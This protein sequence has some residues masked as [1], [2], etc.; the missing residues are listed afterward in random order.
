[1]R[2]ID[3]ATIDAVL[4]F[5]VLVDALHAAH[6]RPRMEVQDTLLGHEA[7][8]YFVRS[9]ND[10]GRFMASKLVT[11][12]PG[13]P[14]RSTLPSV[15]GVVVLFDGTDGRPLVA[16]DGTALTAWRTA[17]DSAL[18]VRLLAPPAPA[19]LLVVGAGQMSRWLVRAHRSVRPSLGR[20]LI[21]NRDRSRAEA[22]AADLRAEGTPAEA[23]TDLRAATR[24]ADLISTCTG[25]L[26]P[27]V[28]GAD[29]KP[30]A[31]L[32]LVG[33]YRNDMREADD[34]AMRRARVY[35]DLRASGRDVGELQIPLANGSLRE[36]DIL[37]DHY[38]LVAGTA[39]GRL[40][41]RDITLVK[42]AGGGHLDLM[43]AECILGLVG[44]DV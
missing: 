3:A 31:H 27:L 25:S 26:V 20:V 23:V 11:S 33:S 13:N 16:L 1:M 19:T 14:G 18:G 38:E 8:A 28:Q 29:L 43:T 30:G 22:V 9:A 34:E 41:D 12:F 35:V 36:A 7:A 10:P 44:S 17:A 4:S 32:D 40:S 2:F 15:Q 39:A 5:P 21:W 37:G 42:N 24:D 6:R